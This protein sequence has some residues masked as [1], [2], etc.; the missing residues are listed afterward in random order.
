MLSLLLVRQKDTKLDPANSAEDQKTDLN[1]ILDL[2]R[3]K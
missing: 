1:S 2:L 3:N